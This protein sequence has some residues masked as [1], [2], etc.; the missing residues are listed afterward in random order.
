M[1]GTVRFVTAGL[2]RSAGRSALRVI[3]LALATALVGAMLLFIST[4]LRTM[5]SSAVHSVPLDWQAPVAS[6]AQATR[7]A[8]LVAQQPDVLES[9]PAATAPFAGAGHVAPAGS[10]RTGTGAVLAA[11]SRY[12]DH[13]K[14]FRLLH[15]AVRPGEVVL[16]QQLAATLQAQV[17][18][19]ITL[20]PTQHAKPRP[21]RVSGVAIVTAADLLF[22]PLDPRLG[23]APA[24]P[25]AQIA[26]MPLET[27]GRTYARALRSL[28]PASLGS[29]VV[30]GAQDVVQ[31]QIQA[32][33]DP[34]GLG[35]SPGQALK[36]A[37]EV[38]NRVERTLTGNVQ[39]VDNLSE[40]L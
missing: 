5:T 23:P 27:F 3:V 6:Q 30:P 36:R 28:T 22:Q 20:T 7:L 13:L 21:Y 19:R 33:A 37:G 39:F 9:A 31:W 17:G 25:P 8:A 38:R 2:V 10:I 35:S 4:S 40:S 14:T 24:Q 29:S 26:T 18:D 12:L 15:G 16:D 11:P 34:A 32:Q 1:S